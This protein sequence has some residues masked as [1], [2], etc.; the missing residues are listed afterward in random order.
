VRRA[1]VRVLV[2]V[3][4]TISA[5]ALAGT[6]YAHTGPV[7]P[8]PVPLDRPHPVFA[9]KAS[10]VMVTVRRGD[11]LTSLAARACHH[12]GFWP[13]L[14]FANRRKVHNP[15][16]IRPGER[17][18]LPACRRTRRKVATMAEGAIPQPVAA[19]AGYV[20]AA[21]PAAAPAPQP[22]A[23]YS[24]SGFEA[25]V[26]AAESGGNPRA[27]N[28]TSGAGGLYQFLPSTWASLGYSGAPQDAPVSVQ[29]AAFAKLYAEAGTS[30]WSGYD[31]C[32]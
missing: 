12:G 11:T 26:I 5:V 9:V 21:V 6:A 2:M 8:S 23:S 15:N 18:R 28:P 19:P 7:P 1:L 13:E 24:G 16:M 32:T 14:W 4:V 22:V 17:L 31:G 3:A 27:V 29:R 20:P 10:P 30:P 25:C